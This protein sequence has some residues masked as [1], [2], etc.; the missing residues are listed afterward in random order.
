MAEQIENVAGDIERRRHT[1]KDDAVFAV[2][3]VNSLEDLRMPIP[4]FFARYGT[5]AKMTCLLLY[6]KEA[7]AGSEFSGMSAHKIMGAESEDYYIREVALTSS[8]N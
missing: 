5:R 2:R 8:W 3:P 7:L 6:S 1:A 4:P